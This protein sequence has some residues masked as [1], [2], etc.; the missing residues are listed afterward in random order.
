MNDKEK[1]EYVLAELKEILEEDPYYNEQLKQ[2][3][4]L[5]LYFYEKTKC[6]HIV[7][8]V[9][10]QLFRIHHKI[11]TASSLAGGN[12]PPDLMISSVRESVRFFR[13]VA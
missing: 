3:G 8:H 12:L 9:L 11:Q 1:L 10:F 6:V 13:F 2:Y 5:L 7:L 4:M